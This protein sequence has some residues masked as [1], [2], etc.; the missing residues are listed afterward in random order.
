MDHTVFTEVELLMC[1][2]RLLVCHIIVLLLIVQ[3]SATSNGYSRR[4]EPPN[5]KQTAEM[6]RGM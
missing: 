4:I 3:C 1:T 2:G 6:F 5:T